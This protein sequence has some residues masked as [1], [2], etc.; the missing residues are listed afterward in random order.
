MPAFRYRAKG[1]PDQV[2]NGVVESP[3]LDNAIV[4]IIQRGLTPIDVTPLTAVETSGGGPEAQATVA[5]SL[6]P[7]RTG[8]RWF[9]SAH[10]L[11]AAPQQILLLTRQI[12]DMVGASVPLLRALQIVSRQMKDPS[13]R[14]VVEDISRFVQNGGSLSGALA[15]H[16]GLFSPFYVNMVRTGETGGHLDKVM[17][18]LAG[19]LERDYEIRGR[20]RSSLIYPLLILAVGILTVAVLFTFVIP[21]L[22]LMFDDLDQE[23]PLPTLAVMRVSSFF[24]SH[25]WWL[26][27]LAILGGMRARRWV[28]SE[29]GRLWFD[30]LKLRTPF[31]GE[32]IKAVETGGLA[33]TLGTLLENGVPM[34]AALEAAHPTVNNA[35]LRKAIRDISHAVSEGSTLTAALQK[36]ALFPEMAAS[37]VAVGEEAGRLEESL[38]KMAETLERQ[39]D[40]M[41][42]MMLA[43]LGPAVLICI[44]VIVGFAVIAMLLPILRMN[45]LM[46]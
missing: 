13:W 38:F 32:F 27:G 4:Q 5:R 41:G 22:S 28:S 44:V 10:H 9:A 7:L 12:S 26:L 18:R 25:W 8:R 15:R 23:L 14:D 29:K 46:G 31:L 43:L 6:S 16:Q 33:R 17:E 20:V 40:Q 37:M 39:S 19:H 30:G 42:Q 34:T 21:R 11:R 24:A 2:V 3:N 35:V 45:V 1:G 36:N